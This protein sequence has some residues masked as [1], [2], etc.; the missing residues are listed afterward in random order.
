VHFLRYLRVVQGLI[1]RYRIFRTRART[2]NWVGMLS[3]DA[4]NVNANIWQS[5]GQA[6]KGDGGLE[7]LGSF[8]Y[9]EPGERISRGF[10]L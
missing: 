7:I 9:A 3:A 8:V 5:N 1:F 6:W 2:D 4:G 10:S